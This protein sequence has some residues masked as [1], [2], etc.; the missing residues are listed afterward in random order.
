[1]RHPRGRKNSKLN[2][3]LHLSLR[4]KRRLKSIS[5]ALIALA[6]IGLAVETFQYDDSESRGLYQFSQEKEQAFRKWLQIRQ[7]HMAA[8]PFVK[9]LAVTNDNRY[10][11]ARVPKELITEIANVNM[12]SAGMTLNAHGEFELSTRMGPKDPKTGIE[13]PR[14][15]HIPLDPNKVALFVASAD[16]KI[17]PGYMHKQF[18]DKLKEFGLEE[19]RPN[20][21]NIKFKGD[22][23]TRFELRKE[24]D[25]LWESGELDEETGFIA[26]GDRDGKYSSLRAQDLSKYISGFRIELKRDNNRDETGR[27]NLFGAIHKDCANEMIFHPLEVATKHVRIDGKDEDQR[28]CRIRIEKVNRRPMKCTQGK[29]R[30][31]AQR[32]NAKNC[33]SVHELTEHISAQALKQDCDIKLAYEQPGADPADTSRYVDQDFPSGA[34]TYETPATLLERKRVDQYNA[35]CGDVKHG[36]L[37]AL[38]ELEREFTDLLRAQEVSIEDLRKTASEVHEREFMQRFRRQIDNVDNLADIARIRKDMRHYISKNRR[39][40]LNDARKQLLRLL[41]EKEAELRIPEAKNTLDEA[42]QASESG[43]YSQY[44]STWYKAYT[45]GQRLAQFGNQI[46]PQHPEAAR[47]VDDL[48]NEYRQ[49]LT[50]GLYDRF[51]K[52][53]QK[54]YSENLRETQRYYQELY[55]NYYNRS[56]VP[57]ATGQNSTNPPLVFGNS[58]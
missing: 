15:T 16:S 18:I 12:N 17:R 56:T 30:L 13:Y 51:V 10:Y 23:K 9:I 41:T 19:V 2:F 57:N 6:P 42:I 25:R 22:G 31:C 5:L 43:N 44:A 47:Q 29:A 48:T 53:Y 1:M 14:P 40:D 35:L 3:G 45:A 46:R 50:S 28:V 34:L 55:N 8:D 37:D 54:K 33:L 38:E 52:S 24:F 26:M 11:S 4:W 49:E 7:E 27:I 21:N 32:T 36:D 39:A 58:F 20:G